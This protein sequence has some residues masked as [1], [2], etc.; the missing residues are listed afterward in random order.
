MTLSCLYNGLVAVL[1]SFTAVL[2]LLFGFAG[3]PAWYRI[4]EGRGHARWSL[5][6]GVIA[7][8]MILA[9]SN[10]VLPPDMHS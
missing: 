7:L 9:T 5:C 6:S 1:G 2:M 10:S 3:L 4:D 8:A